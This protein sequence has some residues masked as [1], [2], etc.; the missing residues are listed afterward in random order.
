MLKFLSRIDRRVIYLLMAVAIIIPIL[1]P[2]NLPVQITK[3]VRG[4]YDEIDRLPAGSRILVV[5]DYEPASQPEVEPMAIAVMRHCLSKNLK[6]VAISYLQLGRGNAEI[7]FNMIQKE[8]EKKGRIL[9]YGEDI[10]NMGFKPG[11]SAMILGLGKDFKGTCVTDYMGKDVYSLPILKDVEGLNDF[12]YLACLHD[13]S[14]I[15]YWILYAYEIVGIK[16]G[17]FCTAVMA[18][19]IYANLDAGQLTGIVGG[20]K[21]A[22]EYEKLLNYRGSAT[23]GMDSQTI[24]HMLIVIF[25]LI[26]NFS[27]LLKERRLKKEQFL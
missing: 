26:G 12:K 3:E 20:L 22:S 11:Y 27:Y 2:L 17:S 1:V 10:A 6:V 25:I 16:I 19:G 4:V 7:V 13:D 21:G 8:F 5:F 9:K 14:S 23:I 24:I 15:S 18:P